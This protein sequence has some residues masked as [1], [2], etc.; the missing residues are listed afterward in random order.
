MGGIGFS[1]LLVL[2]V[3]AL[4]VIGPRRLPEMARTIG[5]LS[6]TAQGAWQTLKSEFQAE[7]DHEHNR[8]ILADTEALQKELK[9]L[10]KIEDQDEP[11]R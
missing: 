3:I 1:E 4:V 5:Q 6:R 8:R 9:D 2:A 10:T 11:P 7:L